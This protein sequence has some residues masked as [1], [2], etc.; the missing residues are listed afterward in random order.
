MCIPVSMSNPVPGGVWTDDDD[1]NANDD[2]G[3][4]M[5]V[6]G[7]LVDKPNEFMS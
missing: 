6:S 2:D 5:I 4:S 3:Q 7:P 1:A